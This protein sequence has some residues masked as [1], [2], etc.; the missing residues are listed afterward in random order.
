VVLNLE[1]GRN[2]STQCESVI[3]EATTTLAP[4]AM[5][6]LHTSSLFVALVFAVSLRGVRGVCGHRV[7]PGVAGD[8]K[9]RKA[10]RIPRFLTAANMPYAPTRARDFP[11]PM[12]AATVPDLA[13]SPPDACS[14]AKRDEQKGKRECRVAGDWRLQRGRHQSSDNKTSS[15]G[16]RGLRRLAGACPKRT[17]TCGSPGLSKA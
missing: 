13:T 4:I 3:R 5:S 11:A 10:T 12:T 7:L 15:T 1:H 17:T 16:R 14:R 2:N 6:L 9:A 8:P